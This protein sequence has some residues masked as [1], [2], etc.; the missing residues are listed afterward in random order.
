MRLAVLESDIDGF[1]ARFFMAT[2][3][4]T[5]I[6]MYTFMVIR[7]KDLAAMLI[8]SVCDFVQD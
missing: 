6:R 1:A 8:E 7:R 5:Y 3:N 4:H 2:F